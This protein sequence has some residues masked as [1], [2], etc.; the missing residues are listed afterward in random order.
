MNNDN[1]KYKYI[2]GKLTTEEV[3]CSTYRFLGFWKPPLDQVLSK[4]AP[5]MKKDYWFY[6]NYDSH[7]GWQRGDFDVPMYER[8]ITHGDT[9][10]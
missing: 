5:C 8:I 2:D 1:S 10:K 3:D 4:K 9:A 6:T 7:Q